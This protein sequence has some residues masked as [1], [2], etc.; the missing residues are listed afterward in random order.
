MKTVE[1]IDKAVD[2]PNVHEVLIEKEKS[3]INGA[4]LFAKCSGCHGVKAD[5]KALNKS[6]SIKGW[7]ITKLTYAINGYKDGSYGGSMKGVMKPQVNKLSSDEIKALAEYIS[8]L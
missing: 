4:A 3:T 5:K 8:K 7:S 6:Q 2:K 1:N